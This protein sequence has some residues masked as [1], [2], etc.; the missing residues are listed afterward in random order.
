MRS[1]KI[2]INRQMKKTIKEVKYRE[3]HLYIR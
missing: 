3:V 2:K 1:I